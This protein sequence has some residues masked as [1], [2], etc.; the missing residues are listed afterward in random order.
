VTVT[1]VSIVLLSVCH[2]ICYAV[3]MGVP[4]FCRT[5]RTSSATLGAYL[6]ASLKLLL[7]ALVTPH[8]ITNLEEPADALTDAFPVLGLH[9]AD[10]GKLL[11]VI[12]QRLPDPPIRE[13][14]EQVR[15]M[16]SGGQMH[17]VG[18]VVAYVN[19]HPCVWSRAAHAQSDSMCVNLW[20]DSITSRR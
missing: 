10:A 11:I 6:L 1:V 19:R 3:A 12:D 8:A 13:D 16:L 15:A 7:D 18:E 2:G 17:G 4:S 5:N 9:A 20:S 14:Q